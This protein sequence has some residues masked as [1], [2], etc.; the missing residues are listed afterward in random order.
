M[1]ALELKPKPIT[2]SIEQVEDRITKEKR[3]CLMINGKPKIWLNGTD[4]TGTEESIKELQNKI[5][6]NPKSYVIDPSFDEYLKTIKN[7][8]QP[9]W[10][11]LARPQPFRRSK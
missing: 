2:I 7:K 8:P 10:P 11:P 3:P 4:L 1:N 5:R 6:N 9:A